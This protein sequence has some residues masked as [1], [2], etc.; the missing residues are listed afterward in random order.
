MLAEKIRIKEVK[1]TKDSKRELEMDNR[2]I[3]ANNIRDE[4]S[5]S[6]LELL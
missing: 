4:V 2:K 6:A 1:V 5:N 3:T